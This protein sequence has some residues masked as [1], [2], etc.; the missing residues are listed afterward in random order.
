MRFGYVALV[1]VAIT[2]ATI[3]LLLV[4]RYRRIPT[5][6]FGYTIGKGGHISLDWIRLK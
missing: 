1:V 5:V 4:A 3:L 2:L 6:R